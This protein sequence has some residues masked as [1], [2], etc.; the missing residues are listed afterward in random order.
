[1]I[2]PN[3]D[4]V[5]NCNCKSC[6]SKDNILVINDKGI[7]KC[8]KCLQEFSIYHSYDYE[9]DLMHSRFKDNITPQMCLDYLIGGEEKSKKVIDRF[10]EYGI[11]SAI[12]QHTGIRFHKNM[13]VDEFETQ[14]TILSRVNKIRH[15]KKFS[16]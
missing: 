14:L 15:I 1:M 8:N 7:C 3:C 11:G 6:N 4:H 13:D 2:C 16:K 5:H 9:W 12:L 10:G